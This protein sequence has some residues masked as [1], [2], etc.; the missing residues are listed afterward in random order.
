MQIGVTHATGVN[1]QQH[2]TGARLRHV[3]VDGSQRC[4]VDN[5]RPL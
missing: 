4:L 2:L 5:A 3:Q 1:L